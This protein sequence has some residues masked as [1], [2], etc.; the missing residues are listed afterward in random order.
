MVRHDDT[1]WEAWL[2]ANVYSGTWL[3]RT[4]LQS[5]D[6]LWPSATWDSQPHKHHVDHPLEVALY[7]KELLV[8]CVYVMRLPAYEE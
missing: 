2:D 3:L 1:S 5:F 7:G 8:I 6:S 4:V